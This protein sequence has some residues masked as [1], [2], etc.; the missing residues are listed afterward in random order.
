VANACHQAY[1]KPNTISNYP[2]QANGSEMLRWA[3]TF[4]A[5]RGIEIHAPV[6]D[7]LLVGGRA[8][9]IEHV[10][11]ATQE[12]MAQASDLMLDGFILRSDAKIVRYPDRYVDDRGVTM[13]SRVTK[14]LNELDSPTS[15]RNATAA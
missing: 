11:A 10:V 3:C 7:A 15:T 1:T 5:E 12:A 4:A 13:W 9:E 2:M 8:E 14:L 6:Q